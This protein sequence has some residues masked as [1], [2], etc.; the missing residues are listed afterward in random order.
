MNEET[1]V[2]AGLLMIE[3]EQMNEEKGVRERIVLWESNKQS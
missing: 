3:D 2:D 1:D